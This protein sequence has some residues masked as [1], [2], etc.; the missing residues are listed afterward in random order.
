MYNEGRKIVPR[1]E[2]KKEE[3]NVTAQIYVTFR[4]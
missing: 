3:N 1:L 4:F 2:I